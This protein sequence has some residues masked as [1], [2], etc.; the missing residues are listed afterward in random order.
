MKE[1]GKKLFISEKIAFIV[2]TYFYWNIQPIHSYFGLYRQFTIT[3]AAEECD[4]SQPY[5]YHLST[6]NNAM[7]NTLTKEYGL[8]GRKLTRPSLPY[9]YTCFVY[10]NNV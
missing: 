8:E 10:C 3:K 1:T 5:K 9:D 6:C 4:S 7:V 2:N